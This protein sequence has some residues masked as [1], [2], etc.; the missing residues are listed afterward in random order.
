MLNF[1]T[2][3]LLMGLIGACGDIS[4]G[5][6]AVVAPEVTTTEPTVIEQP[7]PLEVPV[8]KATVLERSSAK[9]VA[10]E[11]IEETPKPEWPKRIR[12]KSIMHDGEW[13]DVQEHKCNALLERDEITMNS[14][15]E[16]VGTCGGFEVDF[17]TEFGTHDGTIRN[18]DSTFFG[19]SGIAQGFEELVEYDTLTFTTWVDLVDESGTHRQ[20]YGYQFVGNPDDE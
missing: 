11:T 20:A 13:W 1:L 5:E 16:F 2:A 12:M 8:E 18:V 14:H 4:V 15:L 19:A 17:I 10:I 7:E 9:T 3:I 6:N